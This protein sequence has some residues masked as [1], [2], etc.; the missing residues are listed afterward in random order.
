MS[1][2]TIWNKE[3][4]KAVSTIAISMIA[5]TIPA[6]SSAFF[7]LDDNPCH[8]S[9]IHDDTKGRYKGSS[10]TLRMTGIVRGGCS[11]PNPETIEATVQCAASAIWSPSTSDDEWHECVPRRD[12]ET[13]FLET[14][15]HEPVGVNFSVDI[16][17][18][19]CAGK[20][21]GFKATARCKVIRVK[22]GGNVSD[23]RP[24]EELPW[25]NP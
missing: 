6:T 7:Y 11:Q 8:A 9:V 2:S 17:L 20:R 13:V 19:P 24:Q 18:S 12:Q 22:A 10:E 21:D 16:D 23:Y 14:S 25:P 15:G 1:T 3:N 4:I 5:T